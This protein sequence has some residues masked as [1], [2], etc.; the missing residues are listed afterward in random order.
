MIKNYFL[1][2]L[3]NLRK[4]G[5]YSFINIA[6]LSIGIA[7]SILILLWVF[8]ETS[9]NKFHPKYD[10]LYQVWVNA[11]F[12]GKISSWTSVP[13][14]TYEAMKTADS[15]IKKAVVTDWGG[16]HLLTVGENRLM[17]K[18]Y[19]ASEEFLEV[20][21]FSLLKGNAAQVMDDPKSIIITEATAKAL[22]GNDDP[23]NKVIRV[24]NENDLQVTGVLKDIPANSSFEFDFLMTWKFREQI[25]DWVRRN[26]TNWGNYSFQVFV[27][28]DDPSN[29]LAVE[30]NIRLIL[31][32]HGEKETKPEFFL[33]PLSRWRLHGSFDNGVETGGMNDYVQLFTIIAI[34][35]IV[36]ACINFMN[37]ATA[38]SE[39]RAREV[40]VRKSVGSRRMEL[41]LQF[42][43]ESTFIALLA[44]IAAVL[45]AQ[46]IL[47][48]YNRLVD[49][50]LFIDYTSAQFWIFA[51]GLIVLTGLVSGSYPAFYL[52]SF[53]PVKVLK[54]KPT[55]GKG[56]STPRKVLVT[57][58]FGFSILLIIGTLVIYEQIQLIKG[59]EIG[60]DQENLMAVNYTNEVK[61]NYRPIKLDLLASGVVEAV[62][63]SN[64]QITDINSNNFLGW[65]GKPE[66]LRV[67]FTT[68]ATEYDYTKT[69]GIKLLEGRD[70]SEDFK[71]DTSSILINKAALDLMG[72]KDPIGTE[73]DLWGGKRKLIGIT[74]NVLMGSPYDPVK[75][76]FVILDPEWIDAVT[77]RLKKTKDLQASVATVKSI[78]EKHAPAYPFEYRF[79]D[80]EFQKKFTTINLTSQLASLFATLTIIITGL[81]LFGLAAFTAEQR[82]K[83][84]GIRKV[85][86]A[87]VPSLVRLISKD[88]SLLVIISFVFSSPLAWWLLTKYLE[89]YTIRT[90]I[91]W[92]VFPT[93]GLIALAFALLIVSTQALRAAHANPATSLRNE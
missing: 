23:I 72:L 13:L 80:V 56:A 52:S 28:L 76:M 64:S 17:K 37:L 53:Q 60:Y 88:F 87:S 57:L 35:I 31:Q 27:E 49:K 81:G 59:R 73:L 41:I 74:D 86:G 38:R 39:R 21:E 93:T 63:K 32:E 22:F 90:P 84:I 29:K 10:R 55:I 34:F 78:F 9:Y 65:P 45:M 1:V 36:I 48:Y 5:F 18:G 82:T 58:Q 66:D 46:L 40:G 44:F 51:L 15:N 7:C 30:K 61:K 25:S 85:L 19:F 91:A 20:F 8:D 4:N 50:Q 67:I 83:E 33:Y 47:P 69:M 12:D 24:D 16:T 68:I 43:G 62:T 11:R 54:G 77:V 14:P 70:F 71:S 75:P 79:A 89:R 26:T 42:I 2:T 6:G 92:W 3:R